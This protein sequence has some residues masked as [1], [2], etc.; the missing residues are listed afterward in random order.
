MAQTADCYILLDI[1]NIYVSAKNNQFDPIDY[2]NGIPKELVKEYHLA[3]YEDKGTHLL[4][5]HGYPVY[6]EVWAL[7]QES[8][9]IIGHIPTL[10]EWDDNIP[11]LFA[12]LLIKIPTQASENGCIQ[13]KSIHFLSG[14]FVLKNPAL[15]E[16][17]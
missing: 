5:T 11:E 7:Y 8:L 15:A 9:N 17:V 16:Y 1:N 14:F 6:P 13:D 2:I 4:D 10:I 12:P 3:G